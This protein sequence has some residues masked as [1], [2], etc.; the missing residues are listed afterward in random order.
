VENNPAQYG[1]I[2]SDIARGFSEKI[3]AGREYFFKHPTQA[4]H[5]EVFSRYNF[6]LNDAKKRGLPT[7]DEKIKDAIKNGWW[8]ADK[9]NRFLQLRESI[10]NL[11]KTKDN[12]L[13]PSQK[14]Q[15]QS[16]IDRN[17]FILVTFIKERNEVVGYTA[18]KY[19]NERLYD[20]TLLSLTFKNREMTER[21]F[22]DP[23]EYYYLS[24]D[25]VE[26]VRDAFHGN[27][28][29]FAGNMIK[30]VAASTFFQNM[31]Y[32]TQECDAFH[33]WGTPASKCTKYQID[34]LINGKMYKQAVK[35]E[36]ERGKSIPDE[37]MSDPVKFVTWYEARSA[38]LEMESSS[39]GSS[40][41]S[42]S[43]AV[44]SFVGATSED[45]KKMGVKVQKI[46]GKSLLEMAEESGGVL[47]KHQ[48]LNAR[49]GN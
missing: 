48:Y 42:S 7:E 47:E 28:D 33:F 15:I 18:E 44:S 36:A 35:S 29:L 22:S 2:Y 39:S 38:N 45:L 23:D 40:V 13:L 6:I 4:E 1:G 24:D 8:L 20:E 19:A 17:N 14:D 16:Q 46:K 49:D 41:G 25:A 12:L 34:L 21:V 5:F 3:I 32:V 11:K 10:K 26:K 9:E 37:V 27:A 43:T 31:L 30:Y